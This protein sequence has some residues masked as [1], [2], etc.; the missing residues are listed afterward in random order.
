[1]SDTLTIHAQPKAAHATCTVSER[2]A[3]NAEIERACDD[4]CRRIAPAW[5]LDRAIAVNP[6]WGRIGMPLRRVA[7]RMA[8]SVEYTFFPRGTTNC[9]LGAAAAFHPTI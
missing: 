4:A 8:C 3:R 5:P 7:A 6:H 1:M 2:E 9:T